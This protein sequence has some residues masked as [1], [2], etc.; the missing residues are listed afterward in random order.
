MMSIVDCVGIRPL[1]RRAVSVSAMLAR[2][3][4]SLR[5]PFRLACL[6]PLVSIL[7]L[8]GDEVAVA[9]RFAGDEIAAPLLLAAQT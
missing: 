9:F 8:A 6:S 7:R 5:P 2:R 4:L 1:W 3:H